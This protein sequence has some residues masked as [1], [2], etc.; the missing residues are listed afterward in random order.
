MHSWCISPFFTLFL[1][2]FREHILPSPSRHRWIIPLAISPYSSSFLTHSTFMN[3]ILCDNQHRT[4]GRHNGT[5]NAGLT[6]GLC[7]YTRTP[8][9]RPLHWP[10]S[11][12][13]RTKDGVWAVAVMAGRPKRMSRFLTLSVGQTLVEFAFILPLVL[14]LMLGVVESSLLALALSL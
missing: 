5:L 6:T 3:S 9:L 7:D 11:T 2:S 8:H 14:L 10:L 1:M 12:R 13:I 4:R